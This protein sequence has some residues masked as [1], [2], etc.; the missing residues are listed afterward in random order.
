MRDEEMDDLGARLLS[1]SYLPLPAQIEMLKTD[2]AKL[3][4]AI[5]RLKLELA[6]A[7]TAQ[8]ALFNEMQATADGA[9]ADGSKQMK[10]SAIEVCCPV[11]EPRVRALPLDRLLQ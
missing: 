5:G 1:E 4:S 10:Q 2:V 11:C 6:D 9:H 8:I 7:L 3:V